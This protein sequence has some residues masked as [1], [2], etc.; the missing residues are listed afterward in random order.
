VDPNKK[1]IFR[2]ASAYKG[3][4]DWNRVRDKINK[5]L[6]IFKDDAEAV[7]DFKVLQ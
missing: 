1:V 4:K 6:E 2:E 5:A 7:T 3:L